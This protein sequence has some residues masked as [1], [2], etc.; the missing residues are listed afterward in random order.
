M[1]TSYRTKIYRKYFDFLAQYGQKNDI[2]EEL[3]YRS[4]IYD[5]N[6]KT[7]LPQDKDRKILELGCGSGFFLKYLLN[8]GYINCSGIDF[9]EQQISKAAD[10]GIKNVLA[11]DMSKYLRETDAKFGVI[12]LFHVLEHLYKDEIIDLL[13]LIH[14]RLNLN[15]MIIVEVPNAGSPILG[16]HNRYI[17][18]THEVGFTPT[19]L[20][21]VLLACG[22]RRVK[23]YPVKD[24]SPYARL[25]FRIL[26]YFLHSRFTRDEFF[27]GGLIGVGHKED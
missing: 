23:I 21:E 11:T 12:C 8:N 19:S 24:V 4:K 27:E 1:D 25:F 10:L 18:F 6:L 2:C 16:S 7:I 13:E 3:D 15:G 20:Q 17:D 14:D 26:N 5:L 22:F 9:S